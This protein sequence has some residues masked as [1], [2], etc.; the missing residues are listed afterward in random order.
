M[1]FDDAWVDEV[2]RGLMACGVFLW[3]PL[4]C[5]F[6]GHVQRKSIHETNVDLIGLSYNQM[7]NNLTSQA[8]TMELHGAPNDL[9]TNLNP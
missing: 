2:R 9:I 1:T 3:Y 6:V 7:L 8:A 5:E 4:Y